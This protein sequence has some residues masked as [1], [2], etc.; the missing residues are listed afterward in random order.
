MRNIFYADAKR[1]T[2]NSC[3]ALTFRVAKRLI[4]R[5]VYT[6]LKEGRILNIIL[7]EV[8]E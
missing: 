8:S 2:S 4:P 6:V 3:V 1:L 7:L 5:S